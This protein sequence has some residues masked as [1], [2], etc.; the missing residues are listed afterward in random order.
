M[1]CGQLKSVSLFY[2]NDTFK[3][4][5]E[6]WFKPISK[7]SSFQ[8]GITSVTIAINIW[9]RPA[10]LIFKTRIQ[11]AFLEDLVSNFM[12]VASL[13]M[14]FLGQE[15]IFLLLFCFVFLKSDEQQMI[16]SRFQERLELV[17]N[18]GCHHENLL[19]GNLYC[20]DSAL[21]LPSHILWHFWKIFLWEH[22]E[23]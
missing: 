10:G 21:A 23:Q 20:A 19:N 17:F 9:T 22:K 8:P 15:N 1:V 16:I 7:S 4:Y 18:Y 13:K 5:I 14:F 2:T 11:P 3:K 6:R 12:F